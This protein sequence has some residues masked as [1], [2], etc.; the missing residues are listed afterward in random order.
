[1]SLTSSINIASSAL[2]ASQLGLQVTSMNM[3]NAANPSYTRQI[4]ML[5]AI[6]GRVSDPYQIGQ[7]VAVTEVRRQIDE[8][9][10]SRLWAGTAA[11]NSSAQQYGVLAQLETILNEGT[12]FDMSTQLSSFFNS[13]TEATTLLDS[14]AT[15]Q[16]QGEAVASFI[17]N[18]RSDLTT[19]RQQIEDQIDAQVLRANGIL[20]EIATIN[21]TI[22][23]SEI[24]DA[25]ASG[26]RDQRDALVTELSQLM[27]VS[28]HEN[29]AGAY[30]IYSGSTPIVQG[31]RN[32]GVEISRVTDD[33]G[34]LSVRVEII[35]DSTPLPVSGGSIG[36]LL[37]S[38]DGAID[39][40][41]EKLDTLAA[42]LIFE[43]NKLHSTGI[44]EDWLTSSAAT[45]AIPSADRALALNDPNNSTLSGLPFEA[46]NGGFTI[47]VRNDDGSSSTRRIEIDLDG[48][49]STGQPGFGDDTSADDI[50]AAINATPSIGITASFDS[51]GRLQIEA[52][53]GYSFSFSEDTS[54]ALAV[55]GVNS[56]FTGD[57][58]AD[59]GVREDLEVMLGRLDDTGQFIANGTAKLIGDLGNE[60]VSGLGELS[61]QKF[62]SQQA[63][64]IAS[65]TASARNKANADAIIRESLDAQRASVSGVSI[66]EESINLMSY[67]RQYQGAAQV[68]TTA[69]EMFD[70]LLALV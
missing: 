55:L 17:R 18:M 62:W 50:L 5:Q 43:V 38:R 65:K 20:D 3:A 61:I 48:I 29:N 1:M 68:I 11:E 57:G 27:D 56:F 58:A 41:L 42:Q 25:E 63:T 12:E 14:A 37:A 10:Q 44:N 36:G 67:Q 28:V 6:R 34:Q 59:I 26:L 49:D 52:D 47:N 30:D 21:Q 45:L 33:N 13:W 8:A 23:E 46:V 53:P 32:R 16:N 24:G 54:G 40:T 35:A 64:D 69:Q 60:A 2:T 9:L 31:G 66:D 15:I 4:A 39:E 51:S 7:G 19:Q 70:T 22:T